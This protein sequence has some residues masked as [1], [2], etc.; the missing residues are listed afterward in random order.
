MFKRAGMT[1]EE[2]EV[3]DN[4]MLRAIDARMRRALRP[5]K[6]IIGLL[7]ILAIGL[8]GV[9]AQ[10]EYYHFTHPTANAIQ[11]ENI[12][13]CDGNNTY[14]ADQT[15]IWKSYL[16][17]QAKESQDT[18][19]ELA[20]LINTLANGNKAEIA[21]IESILATSGA[22]DATDQA[23]FVAQVAATNQPRD[24]QALFSTPGSGK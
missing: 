10:L 11:A 12:A 19:A 2:R 7:I 1:P 23:A 15:L 13:N 21:Q 18:S 5:A 6:F 4:P 16:E 3:A 9:A 24:C 20:A 8:V 22:K 17:L 14:R